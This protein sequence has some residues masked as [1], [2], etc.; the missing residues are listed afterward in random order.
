MQHIAVSMAVGRMQCSRSFLQ[1]LSPASRASSCGC[2]VRG[3]RAPTK[4]NGPWLIYF[5][6]GTEMLMHTKHIPD[7]IFG[8]ASWGHFLARHLGPTGA[9]CHKNENNPFRRIEIGAQIL[10]R[11]C[12]TIFGIE[13][14]RR[15]A[16]GAG[17]AGDSQATALP[18]APWSPRCPAPGPRMFASGRLA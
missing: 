10:G 4:R 2:G 5:C 18:L 13:N 11:R 14:L 9:R 3:A 17:S 12:E 15:G 1:A 6:L 16:I 8:P 7:V